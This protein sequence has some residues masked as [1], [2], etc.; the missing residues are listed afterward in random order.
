MCKFWKIMNVRWAD[1]NSSDSP[2]YSWDGIKE[3]VTR[4]HYR[5]WDTA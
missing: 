2:G 3:D 4:D 5:A 1:K